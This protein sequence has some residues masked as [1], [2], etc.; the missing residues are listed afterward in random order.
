MRKANFKLPYSHD[1]NMP[2]SMYKHSISTKAN[3][4][5]TKDARPNKIKYDPAELLGNKSY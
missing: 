3:I 5:A 1:M 2:D 4:D